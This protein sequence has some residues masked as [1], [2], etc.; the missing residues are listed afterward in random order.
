MKSEMQILR[1]Y[2]GWQTILGQTRG[3]P[4]S[5]NSDFWMFNSIHDQIGEARA[6][7]KEY[8]KTKSFENSGNGDG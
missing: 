1:F 6:K 2:L 7:S 3:K 5:L 4:P 8:G